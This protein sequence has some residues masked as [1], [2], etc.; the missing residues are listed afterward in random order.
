M[1]ESSPAHSQAARTG[2]RG[3]SRST[4]T[5]KTRGK[6]RAQCRA[7]QPANVGRDAR[8]QSLIAPDYPV[9][10][11][12]TAAS[13]RGAGESD[14]IHAMQIE[15]QQNG[16]VRQRCLANVEESQG[17]GANAG[18]CGECG[19]RAC[20]FA[21]GSVEVGS[22]VADTVGRRLAGSQS[23]QAHYPVQVPHTVRLSELTTFRLGG[24][25]PAD[26]RHHSGRDRGRG[27]RGGSGEHGGARPRRRLEPGGRRRR[28][29]GPD[30]P[31]R[32]SRNPTRA[33]RRRQ[34][35]GHS[36]GRRTLG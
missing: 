27:W 4:S 5:A 7:D 29:R 10:E 35:A 22:V 32:G 33:Q 3:L 21:R 34:N 11:S 18:R 25:A 9:L 28:H 20:A 2:T 16:T 31:D 6:T 1:R 24:P 26:H 14:G 8:Q 13:P 15:S 36:R 19:T 23:S 30:C 12:R 17:W